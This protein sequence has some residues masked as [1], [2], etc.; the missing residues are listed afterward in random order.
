MSD[1]APGSASIGPSAASVSSWA[2]FRHPIFAILWT[3]TVVSNIGTWMQNAAA[4]WLMTG[5]NPDPLIVSLVQV[6]TTL[7]MFLFGIPAGALAD[8][9][10][11]RKLLI[12]VQVFLTVVVTGFSLL[13]WLNR[14]TPASLLGFTFLMGVSAALIAPAWQSIVPQLVPRG[15]LPPAVAANSVGINVSRAIGPALAGL[16]IGAL[17]IAAPF[18]INAITSVGVIA[19]LLWWRPQES[20]AHQLPPERFGSAMMIGLR[21]ARRNPHLRATL[22]RAA[23]FFLFASA[24]WALLPLLARNQ[25]QGGPGLYGILLGAIGGSAVIGAL[26]LP[27]LKERLGADGL[28]AAGTVGTAVALVLFGLARAPATALVAS[29]IAGLSWIAVLATINVSAQLGLPAW[30]RG[31]GLALFVTVM[32][33]AMSLGSMAWGQ[34]ATHIG[35]QATH[36]V[37][38]AGLVVALLALRRWK[39]Q[40]GAGVD[41]NPSMHWPAPV[42]AQ[43]VDGDRGPVLVTVEYRINPADRASF[44]DALARLSDQR[45]RDGA[46]EW[47]VFEDAAEPGRIVETFLIASWLEH[48]RQ[49]ERVTHEGR[50]LQER[51]TGFHKGSTPPAVSHLIAAEVRDV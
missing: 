29:S 7:P 19:A 18:W 39:L 21:H 25:I 32:F 27:L 28:A 50:D 45:L 38:A 51:D 8:I 42:L 46:F 9:L 6:A 44:L 14:I 16:L 17:G 43:D 4:G 1:K 3:A 20:S 35:L 22:I 2:P 15:E 41:L 26:I 33:G 37:A 47:N 34:V 40:T 12:V 36:I 5:L 23:G 13:V 31:R 24:Y 10:D 30:V 11:R 49:H 48:M